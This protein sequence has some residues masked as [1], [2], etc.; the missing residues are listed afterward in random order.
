MSEKSET[1]E[2]INTWKK[3]DRALLDIKIKEMR[4]EN[5][6]VKNRNILNKMLQ[7]AFDHR[8]IR[9]SSGLVDF[10]KFIKKHP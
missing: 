3:S 9:K 7:Y 5:Y 1:K 2:W 4:A 8:E 6:Y 10:Q